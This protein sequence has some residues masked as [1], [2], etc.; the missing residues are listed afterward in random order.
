MTAPDPGQFSRDFSH[1]LTEVDGAYRLRP[2]ESLAIRDRGGF[3]RYA[4]IIALATVPV[5]S[6]LAFINEVEWMLALAGT[7]IG[8]TALTALWIRFRPMPPRHPL[9][10]SPDGK[11]EYRGRVVRSAGRV[12]VVRAYAKEQGDSDSF[13]IECADAD[14]AIVELPRKFFAGCERKEIVAAAPVLARLLG[15]E[16]RDELGFSGPPAYTRKPNR[17]V[18]KKGMPKE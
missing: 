6:A 16:L 9:V 5:I 7:W 12:T 11:I 17:K 15:A 18:K 13:H 10:I 3:W 8:L 14:G 4:L 2:T 1:E